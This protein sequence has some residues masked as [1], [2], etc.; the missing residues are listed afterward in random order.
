MK[1]A[2]STKMDRFMHESV[3][4]VNLRADELAASGMDRTE[5]MGVAMREVVAEVKARRQ[6]REARRQERQ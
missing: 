5:A 3:Q 4:R 1:V 6:E 2:R